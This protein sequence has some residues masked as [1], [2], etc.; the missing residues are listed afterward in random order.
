MTEN[1]KELTALVEEQSKS[2]NGEVQYA[3]VAGYYESM[4]S[5]LAA[6]VPEVAEFL[7]LRVYLLS[8]QKKAA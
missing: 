4:L 1:I 5:R 6:D 7:Q 2:R 3:Y 8:N